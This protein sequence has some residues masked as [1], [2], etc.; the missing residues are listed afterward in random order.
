[1]AYRLGSRHSKHSGL[2]GFLQ[3]NCSWWA[4]TAIIPLIAA[5]RASEQFQQP[6][7]V[8]REKNLSS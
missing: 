6:R 2:R 4:I 7:L 1:M 3:V 8:W 5:T